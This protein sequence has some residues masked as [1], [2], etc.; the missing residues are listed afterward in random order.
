MRVLHLFNSHRRGGGSDNSWAATI[1]ASR[2]A[3][4]EVQVLSRD[5]TGIAPTLAGRLGAALSG[6]YS[7]GSVAATRAAIEAFRPDVVH[8]H[9]LYPLLSP[10]VVRE[11]DR[12]GVAVVHSCY[13]YRLTCPTATHFRAGMPC[14]RCA[15]G[16]EYQAILANCRGNY[17]ESIAFAARAAMASRFGLFTRHVHEFIVVSPFHRAWLERDVGVSPDRITVAPCIVGT[18]TAQGDP[19]RGKYIG[20]AG[21]FVPEKG[22]ELLVEA[23]RRTGLPVRLA[24][25]APSHPAV[26]PGDPVECVVTRSRAEL[27]AFYRGARMLVVPSLWNETFCIVG[28]EAMA[29]GVPVVAARL[30]ALQDLVSENETGLFFTP[31]DVADLAAQMRRLWDDPSLCHRMGEAGRKWVSSFFSEEVHLSRLNSAYR[32]AI[33]RRAIQR[34]SHA[35]RR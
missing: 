3:G 29:C 34:Q 28:A 6:L 11:A 27:E 20:F 9:E 14:Y 32:R 16:R 15:G 30:G 19:A 23:A 1:R 2:A 26:R 31:A 24:G 17:G 21:R 33:E 18:P 25:N 10:W 22:V 5:S 13:D 35:G 8:T 7:A 12:M 4:I